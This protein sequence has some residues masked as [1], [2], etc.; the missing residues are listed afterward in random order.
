MKSSRKF[1][2]ALEDSALYLSDDSSSSLYTADQRAVRRS[3]KKFLTESGD[4]RDSDAEGRGEETVD[5]FHDAMIARISK[6]EK[7]Y[8][9]EEVEEAVK[10]SNPSKHEVEG[11]ADDIACS[12][13]GAPL[14]WL[15]PA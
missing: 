3:I 8:N 14:V 9:G 5:L 2:V 10:A 7:N 1:Q 11:S 4:G 6:T 12:I 13:P 15:P